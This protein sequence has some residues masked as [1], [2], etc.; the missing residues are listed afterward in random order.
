M[1]EII[2]AV[3]IIEGR[4]VRLS[5]GDYSSKRVY[6]ELPQE[7]VR[8]FIDAGLPRVHAVDLD[9][10][11]LGSPASLRT[12]E[13]MASVDGA[14]I[15][16]GGGLKTTGNLISAI[17]AGATYLVSGSIAAKDPDM[18]TNWLESFGNETMILGA[19]AKYGKIAVSGWLHTE[20][21]SIDDLFNRFLPYGLNQAIVTD[22]SCDG[23]LKGPA[24]DLY[25]RL[26][27]EYPMIS[28]TVSGGISS[29]DDIRRLADAGQRRVIVG[30]ALYEG[31][32]TLNDLQHFIANEN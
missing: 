2:P 18:F 9:G 1:I 8:R 24:F 25:D 21:V 16:W 30:K 17:N 12:L 15:E 23:M 14:Y 13:A 6:D 31:K 28:V 11:K 26:L 22:I 27:K 4:C 7:M 20:D 29:I 19:D 32:I 5:Q 3:D 10:A